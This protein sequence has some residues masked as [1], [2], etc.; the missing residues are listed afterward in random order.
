MKCLY[1]PR[2]INQAYILLWKR[3][4][5]LFLTLPF[6][7]WITVGGVVGFCITLIGVICSAMFLRNFG[8][9]K[10]NGYLFH[11]VWYHKPKKLKNSVLFKGGAFPPSYIRHIAG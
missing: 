6:I 5:M 2:E 4:E 9:D 11:W 7:F 10:P 1:I 8:V 3:D